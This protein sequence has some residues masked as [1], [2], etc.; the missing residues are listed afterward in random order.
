MWLI[1]RGLVMLGPVIVA[2]LVLARVKSVAGTAVV[3]AVRP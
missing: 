1:G 3:L 2:D